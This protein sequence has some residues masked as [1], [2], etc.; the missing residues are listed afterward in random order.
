MQ[1]RL[2]DQSAMIQQQQIQIKRHTSADFW[3][4]TIAFVAFWIW[5]N[6]A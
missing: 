6:E 3:M 1:Y 2:H 4:K 5:Y